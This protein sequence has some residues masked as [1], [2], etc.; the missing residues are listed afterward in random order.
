ML[1]LTLGNLFYGDDEEIS[2]YSNIEG[3][4]ILI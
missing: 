1:F 3:E 2:S 4:L